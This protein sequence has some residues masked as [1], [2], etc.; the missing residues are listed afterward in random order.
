MW[1]FIIKTLQ[2]PFY[3]QK[4]EKIVL[5]L[6]DFTTMYKIH[7]L[8]KMEFINEGFFGK[9]LNNFNYKNWGND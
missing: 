5:S 6:N 1:F 8:A 3:I 9:Y 7:D 4:K 2:Y